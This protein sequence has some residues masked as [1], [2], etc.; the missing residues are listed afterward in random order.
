MPTLT[1]PF[2]A[3][4]SMA[5]RPQPSIEQDGIQLRPW[6][7]DDLPA[8]LAGYGDPAVQRWH[9]RSMDEGEGRQWIA[10]WTGRWA[11]ETGAGW[12]VVH[13]GQVAGQISLTRLHLPDGLGEVSYWVLPVARGHR[14]A[15]RA[16]QALADWGF[17]TLGLHR[18]EVA[19]STRNPASCRVAEVAGFPAEGTRRSEGWH[20]D[21]WHDMHQ[22]VRINGDRPKAGLAP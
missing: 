3:P 8:V 19:H 18:I 5:A 10:G 7:A 1:M 13:D 22:H 4:G 15:P 16:L 6:R 11:G 2:I 20:A 17:G 14:I 12:A 21:G 9:C